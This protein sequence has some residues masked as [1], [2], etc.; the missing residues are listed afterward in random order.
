MGKIDLSIP[1][2]LLE[3]V[4]DQSGCPI[5]PYGEWFTTKII[6]QIFRRD[7]LRHS[8]CI[9]PGEY[10]FEEYSELRFSGLLHP[11]THNASS[12]L[13]VADSPMVW[14]GGAYGLTTMNLDY[15]LFGLVMP[16]SFTIDEKIFVGQSI[17]EIYEVMEYGLAS[18][19]AALSKQSV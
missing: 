4:I 6:R 2:Q 19:L 11:G 5:M 10:W 16:L 9:I 15:D 18:Y 8:Y 12:L 7:W 1:G 14:Y 17:T 13:V 3:K